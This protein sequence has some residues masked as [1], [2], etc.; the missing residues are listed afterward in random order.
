MGA[1]MENGILVQWNYEVG[2]PVEKGDIICEIETAKGNI[3]VEIWESGT[4]TKLLVEPGAKIP[5]GDVMAVLDTGEAGAKAEEPVEEEPVEPEEAIEDDVTGPQPIAGASVAA[6]PAARRRATELGVALDE[7]SG[8]GP[9]GVIK[10]ED[11][12][13]FKPSSGK[14]H[15]VTP[16]ARRMARESGVDTDAVEAT[17]SHDKVT[18]ADVERELAGRKTAAPASSDP[19]GALRDA[20]AR[21]MARSKREIPHYYLQTEADVTATLQWM[22]EENESR[23]V[24]ER[25]VFGALVARAVAL[26]AADVPEMNGFFEDESFHAAEEVHVGFAVAMRGGG[27]VAPAIHNT[28]Q[29]SLD[30]TMTAIKDVVRRVRGGKLRSS[31][32]TDP[33]ITVTN[34][35]D[36]G[37]DTVFGIIYPPQV[38]IVGVG[39]PRDIPVAT[40]GM[41]GVR[42]CVQLT[43]SG[44]HRVSDGLV[45]AKFLQSI[46]QHLNNPEEL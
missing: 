13:G 14:H 30:E 46:S 3:D 29:K 11:V 34:L 42:T 18:K 45:G 22:N 27:V 8:S 36:L 40:E 35:G 2:D 16:V 39:S 43:L 21:A 9:D 25:L 7:V 5:V 26:A 44:D 37:V 24:K 4:I 12:E 6:S 15:R 38:A 10:L 1:D 19:Q 41:V 31:E 28:D 17:G 33:T 23:S 32:M 20:I